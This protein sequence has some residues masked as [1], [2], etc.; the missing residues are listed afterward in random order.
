M[1]EKCSQC[2]TL[3]SMLMPALAVDKT[4]LL[5]RFLFYS[6]YISVGTDISNLRFLSFYYNRITCPLHYLMFF[7]SNILK[8]AEQ[9]IHTLNNLREKS[10]VR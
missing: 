1:T 9:K 5:P 10:V 6:G 4:V 3:A 8:G 2:S 7:W